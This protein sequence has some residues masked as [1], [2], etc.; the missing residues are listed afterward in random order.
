[1]P[2]PTNNRFMSLWSCGSDSL[3]PTSTARVGIRSWLILIPIDQGS[4]KA[5]CQRNRSVCGSI[6]CPE[7]RH[8]SQS[9]SRHRLLICWRAT[10]LG[11][12]GYDSHRFDRCF[13]HNPSLCDVDSRSPGTDMVVSVD[14]KER[15][16][17]T[18]N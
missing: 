8:R 11:D 12:Q 9:P 5:L 4:R 16:Y 3:H 13:C 7:Y 15:S 17:K 18:I 10:S 1:V 14:I 2:L 6:L